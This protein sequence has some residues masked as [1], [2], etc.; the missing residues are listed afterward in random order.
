[1]QIDRWYTYSLHMNTLG[2]LN[3]F[4][5]IFTP[6]KPVLSVVSDIDKTHMFK[7][8]VAKGRCYFPAS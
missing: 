1:M 3:V 4:K 6:G 8:D 5:I 7:N 2:F